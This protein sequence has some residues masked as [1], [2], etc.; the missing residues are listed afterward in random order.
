MEQPQVIDDGMG[1]TSDLTGVLGAI[2]FDGKRFI[3]A[4]PHGNV[5]PRFA[6]EGCAF[7]MKPKYCGSAIDGKARE[8]FGGDCDERD[9][10]YVEAPNVMCTP[11]GV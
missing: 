10:I 7:Y 9:V 8:A 11:S 6:C 4:P 1:G 2:T 3:E 5:A